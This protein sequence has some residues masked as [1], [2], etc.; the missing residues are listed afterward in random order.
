M[1]K[2]YVKPVF[3]AEAFEGTQSVASCGNG[4]I[5]TPIEL[6]KGQFIC[7]TNNNGSITGDSGHVIGGQNGKKGSALEY[8]D[9]AGANKE[10]SEKTD[11]YLFTD[12]NVVCD[13]LWNGQ[14]STV[15]GWSTNGQKSGLVWDENER[16]DSAKNF[17]DFGEKLLQFFT[18]AGADNSNHNPGYNG[19]IFFS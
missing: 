18:G 16:G 5:N 7:Y 19:E 13:F 17:F 10:G 3:L 9:A 14:G 15:K 12:A 8:W 11:V 2:A 4:S 6:E 1:R